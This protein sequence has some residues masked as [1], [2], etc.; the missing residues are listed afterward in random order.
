MNNKR[1]GLQGNLTT[2]QEVGEGFLLASQY[3]ML[4]GILGLCIFSGFLIW[5]LQVFK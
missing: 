1:I 3:V 4:A 5:Y 2:I